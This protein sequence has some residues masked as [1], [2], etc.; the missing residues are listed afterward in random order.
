MTETFTKEIGTRVHKLACLMGRAAEQRLRTVGSLTFAQFRI[1]V[2]VL[3]GAKLNQRSIAAH[4]GITEAAVS[5]M[6]A[7]LQRRKLV[8]LVPDPANRRT[9]QLTLTQQGV[10][11]AEHAAKILE[12]QFTRAFRQVSAQERKRFLHILD[13]LISGLTT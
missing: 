11:L 10:K 8:R 13:S 7:T 1:L 3:H 6:L 12:G 4:H 9:N 2:A 5:R